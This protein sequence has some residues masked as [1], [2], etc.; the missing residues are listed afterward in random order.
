MNLL[1]KVVLIFIF[2][3]YKVFGDDV[4]N[5]KYYGNLAFYGRGQ[6]KLANYWNNIDEIKCLGKAKVYFPYSE[7]FEQNIHNEDSAQNQPLVMLIPGKIRK[8]YS[9]IGFFI[10]SKYNTNISLNQYHKIKTE[11][12]VIPPSIDELV[13][14]GYTCDNI[15][16]PCEN[17]QDYNFNE[18]PSEWL[19]HVELQLYIESS[20]I[21]DSEDLE[22]KDKMSYHIRIENFTSP[23]QQWSEC[24]GDIISS[25]FND[26]DSFVFRNY[27]TMPV[28]LFLGNT[29]FLK[30]EPTYMV[31]QGN[32]QHH[33]LDLN[34]NKKVIGNE[35]VYFNDTIYNT[36]PK[37]S[38]CLKF[39]KIDEGEYVFSG[40]IENGISAPPEAISLRVLLLNKGNFQLRINNKEWYDLNELF[41]QPR[42]CKIPLGKEIELL[43]DTRSL[44][45]SNPKNT[46]N[47]D[48]EGYWLK[49]IIDA[50]DIKNKSLKIHNHRIEDDSCEAFFLYDFI[51]HHTFP[52]STSSYIKTK[53][54]EDG[55]ECNIE[56]Q[57]Q[58]DWSNSKTI[59]SWPDDISL[60][61]IHQS[62]NVVIPI[63]DN[64]YSDFKDGYHLIQDS[65]M[66]LCCT[67]GNCNICNIFGYF[68]DAEGE[69]SNHLI[70]C[71]NGHCEITIKDN[72][73]FV[74]SRDNSMISCINSNCSI[75]KI[76][77]SCILNRF[78]VIK[79]KSDEYRLCTENNEIKFDNNN[80]KYYYP[81]KKV[82]AS[83]SFP[84]I[85][86]GNDI[87]LLV[88]D[89]YSI[90]QFYDKT[91]SK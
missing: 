6:R 54:N 23:T 41:F 30:K 39:K 49:S 15:G 84:I 78:E 63:M 10:P 29:M 61:V 88:V 19:S 86:S 74:N 46:V 37:N 24:T 2:I 82:N 31:R 52:N 17:I 68:I 89:E 59:K 55:P 60:E 79:D 48:V 18:N 14:E 80:S 72:G 22:E 42:N 13:S 77:N 3:V 90:T 87:I 8:S 56:L 53:L 66:L 11:M 67:N 69:K 51:I 45:Y 34:W 16:L 7:F 20:N 76:S 12:K 75:N 81:K 5:E 40:H 36:D 38:S 50:N 27:G 83:F 57:T 70:Y 9:R 35:T 21:N 64:P 26:Y 91:K 73:Y 32:I 43:I 47:N 33:F 4:V 58:E 44:F 1:I 71:N 25:N 62:K 65:D 85:E 28:Y